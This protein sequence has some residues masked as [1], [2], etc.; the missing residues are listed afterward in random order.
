MTALDVWSRARIDAARTEPTPAAALGRPT[1]AVSA[2]HCDDHEPGDECRY[3]VAW[4]INPHMSIGSVDFARAAAE[5]GHLVAALE[6]IG[7]VVQRLP[8]VHGAY[9]SVFVKDPALLLARS[10]RKRAVLANFAHPERQAERY[11]RATTLAERGYEIVGEAAGPTWEG[12]DVVM[13]PT[14]DGMFLGHGL[15]S[16][17]AAATW[18]ERHAS[19]PVYPLELTTSELYH[20]DMALSVLPD[21]TALVCPW[22][23]T[24]SA[25]RTLSTTPSIRQVI[26]VDRALAL[27]FGLNLV[28]IND[29]VVI[30]TSESRVTAI[31]ASLGYRTIEVPLGE[32]H[33]A[34]G[35][36]A[37]LVATVHPDPVE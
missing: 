31:V 34:G 28:T 21:G 8:F 35:S 17:R 1:F 4:S 23:L 9:D 7:A 10:N 27:E 29:T 22:A 36:A 5:H 37:C 11:A 12:G 25:L 3:Q 20:L 15:R 32:F 26:P 18:L 24:P 14:G 16:E 33:L 2:V 30:G 6:A 19:L 13:L